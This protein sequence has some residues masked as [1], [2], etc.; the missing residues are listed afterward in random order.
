[1]RI[2]L[3]RNREVNQLGRNPTCSELALQTSRIV[4]AV[5]HVTLREWQLP[6]NRMNRLYS[7]PAPAFQVIGQ[8]TRAYASFLGPRI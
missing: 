8:Q 2:P 6:S 3:R 1:M 7:R 5:L 4:I